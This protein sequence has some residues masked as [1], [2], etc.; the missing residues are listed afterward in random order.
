MKVASTQTVRDIEAAVD[1][2]LIRYDQ[3]MLNAGNA[4]A[5]YLC[6]HLNI[7]QH[8]QVVVLVGKGNNGGDG[9]VVA[10]YLAEQTNAHVHVYML[11]DRTSADANYQKIVAT[12]VSITI[13]DHDPDLH[14][15][16]DIISRA[17]VI[18]D[19]LFGIGVRLPIRG[20]AGDIMQSVKQAIQHLGTDTP[21]DTINPTRPS[22]PM[23]R[24]KPFVFA[25]DCPSGIDC[26]TGA[27]D[28]NTIPADL[29]MTFI[30][31]KHGQFMFPAARYVGEL[32]ISQIGIPDS[33]PDLNKLQHIVIDHNIIKT[34]LPKR[35]IDGHKGTFGKTFIV[36]GSKNYIGATALSAEAAYR[37]GVGLVTIGTTSAIVQII[38]SQ[39]REPTFVHLPDTDNAIAHSAADQVMREAQGYNALLI[40][41]GL[42]QHP[43]TIDF[44]HT[45]ITRK[46]LPPL[47]I[48]ADALNSL[49]Q[50]GNWW[51]FLPKDAI[52]T[53]HPGEMARLTGFD[54]QQINAN[55]W[56]I[57]TEMAHKWQVVV[58]LKGAHTIVASP[59]G[60]VGVVPFKTDALGTAGT[61]DVLAGLIAGFRTQGA[62]A[63]D[64]AIIGVYCHA[65]AGIIA[66]QQVGHARAVIAGDVLDALGH[67][68]AQIEGLT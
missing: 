5:T 19:A 46:N 15:L 67:T 16:S 14:Q 68:F 39:L 65:L 25:I 54:T 4:A 52:I 42:G 7:T 45:L 48:D 31:A 61:G 11:A 49:S 22:Q 2:T 38:A 23:Q 40:G 12:D 29:T 44:V 6:H 66:S 36:A 26:D 59:D 62:S 34:R 33:Q 41:C 17:D 55:R 63:F 28:D 10:H 53:P 43:S 20:R 24:P 56:Q 60:Q 27:A 37:S 3:M 64:S 21:I 13:A 50:L 32:V 47:V 18:V 57:A 30:T 8:T 9:L 35:P 58:V 1:A 51:E